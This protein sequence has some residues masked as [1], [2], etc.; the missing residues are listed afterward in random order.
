MCADISRVKQKI[1][2]DAGSEKAPSFSIFFSIGRKI[3]AHFSRLTG[4]KP[5]TDSD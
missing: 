3:P 1:L 2:S 4:T 5:S